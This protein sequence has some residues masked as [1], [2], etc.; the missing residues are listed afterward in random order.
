MS[1]YGRSREIARIAHTGILSGI[2]LL[3]LT[4]HSPAS[5]QD[6]SFTF[7]DTQQALG[8]NR[9]DAIFLGD[10]NGDG[11]RDAVVQDNDRAPSQIWLN[12]GNGTM[13][14]GGRIGDTYEGL[15]LFGDIDG[16]G[17]LDA[18]AHATRLNDGQGNFSLLQM[19]GDEFYPLFA[20]RRARKLGDLDGDGDLDY[21][22][23]SGV[24][25]NN[26]QGTFTRTGQ[27]AFAGL[28]D[29]LVLDDLDGDGDLDVVVLGFDELSIW[30]NSGVATFTNTFNLAMEGSTTDI[31]VGDLDR[32]DDRDILI[33]RFNGTAQI[34]TN[35]G[36]GTFALSTTLVP[37]VTV[38]TVQQSALGDLNGDGALDI[39]MATEF[40]PDLVWR[41]LGTGQFTLAWAGPANHTS[42]GVALGDLNGDDVLDMMFANMG[43]FF[44]PGGGPDHVYLNTTPQLEPLPRIPRIQSSAARGRPGS[45]FV[46]TASSLPPDSSATLTIN[47]QPVSSQGLAQ[48]LRSD[49]AGNLRL[50]LETSSA[51]PGFYVVRLAVD[52]IGEPLVRSIRLKENAELHSSDADGATQITIPAGIAQSVEELFLPLLSR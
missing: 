47:G 9:S 12:D 39:A 19:N 46:I 49:A 20:E 30:L 26:G 40:G 6:N 17:D 22:S 36:R 32:D 51:D 43:S 44:T 7:S 4:L 29:P 35:S 27:E 5:T 50:L 48:D 10:L 21:A 13:R 41:N 23:S 52:G 31:A 37:E 34:Y 1:R 38:R 18:V 8:T 11:T 24:W 28:L 33:S 42:W 25:L 2:L 15:P 45:R 14:D 3:A 16:D